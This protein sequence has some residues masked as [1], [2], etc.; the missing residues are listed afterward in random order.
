[1]VYTFILIKWP[2]QNE[3]WQLVLIV[4]PPHWP[5]TLVQRVPA[6]LE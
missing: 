6:A 4:G 2:M 3:Q 1:M 5:N